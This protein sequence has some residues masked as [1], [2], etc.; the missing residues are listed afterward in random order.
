[1]IISASYRTDIPAY[2]V[3][4]FLNRL[5]AEYAE[6]RNPYNGKPAHVSLAPEYVSG[7]VFWTRNP[8]PFG[9]GFEAVAARGLP[10]VIQMTIT[11]Y[12]RALEPGV[13]DT[14]AAVNAFLDLADRWGPRAAVWRYDPVLISSLTPRDWHL[15]NFTRLA[16]KLSGATDEVVLSHAH[17]YQK[18]ARNLDNA[19][20]TENFNWQDPPTDAKTALLN[21]LGGIAHEHGMTP[22]LCSQPDLLSDGLAPAR[23]IDAARLADINGA[24]ITSRQRGQRPGCLCAE[25]RDIGRYDTCPQGCAYCYANQSRAAAARNLA[26]QD[27]CAI[28]L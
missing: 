20:A 12:P 21:A 14:D 2:Y 18:S 17:I 22:T 9:T 1:M 24:P 27:A 19:G 26:G 28:Q 8:A 10:F 11:G 6:V 25:A 7:F 5:A 13:L 16:E 3:E 23:C 15:E 4:W